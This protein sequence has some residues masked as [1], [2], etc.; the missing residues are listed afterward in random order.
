MVHIQTKREAYCLICASVIR[1]I[2][3]SRIKNRFVFNNLGIGVSVPI[4]WR[5][6][7]YLQRQKTRTVRVAMPRLGEQVAPCFGYEGGAAG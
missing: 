6:S 7:C 1:R 4:G 3:F 5:E 2:P